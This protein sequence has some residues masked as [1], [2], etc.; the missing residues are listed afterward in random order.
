MI[1]VLLSVDLVLMACEVNLCLII[2]N[3]FKEFNTADLFV[4]F[5]VVFFA[6]TVVAFVVGADRGG[7]LKF[8]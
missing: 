5:V 1:A 4:I 6:L 8:F 7:P 2:K 3:M